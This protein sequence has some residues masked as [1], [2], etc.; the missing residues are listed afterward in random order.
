M[1]HFIFLLAVLCYI[2]I[3]LLAQQSE[4]IQTGLPGDNFSLEGALQLFKQSSNPED[5]EKSLNSADNHVNN[6]DIDGDDNIDYIKVIGKQEGDLH[7]LILQVPISDTES[8][9]IAVIEIEKTGPENVIL[10]II[11]DEEIFG[12]EI[13]VEPSD[14]EAD[15][16]QNEQ[17]RRGPAPSL[18]ATLVV[19][20]WLWPSIRFMYGPSYRPW[21]S[22]WRWRVYP[23][24]WRPWRP[25]SW[26]VWH[27]LRAKH[28]R[29]TLRIAQTHR[30]AR[31]HTVYKS[32][33]VTSSTVRVRHASAHANYKVTRSNTKVTGPKG[34]SVTKKSTTVKGPRGNVR[35]QKSTTVKKSRRG[36]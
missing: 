2:N 1:R 26:A 3:P 33:R 21:I 4:V 31:A 19:N 34:N 30:V 13:I 23:N 5:F 6:L 8:Q 16:V 20:V 12:E 17:S 22:P 24:W 29:P 14:G 32:V 9:D 15:D 18:D 11:G 28:Y 25:I 35:T 7:L 36:N 10:Q 27:P